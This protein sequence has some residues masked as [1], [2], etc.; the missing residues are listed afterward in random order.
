MTSTR[1]V[2]TFA[3]NLS[4]LEMST[5]SPFA[6][7]GVLQHYAWGGSRYLADFLGLPPQNQ[8]IAE[9]WM[10]MHPK[11]PATVISSGK[12]LA[13]V[14]ENNPASMLGEGISQRFDHR[15]P[16]L[17][18]ILDVQA[19][20]SI[21]VHPDKGT[22]EAGYAREEAAGIPQSAPHRNYR[23]DNHK[24]ELGVAISD[25]YLLHG[26][27]EEAAIAD[28]LRR[29]PGWAD[30]H[31]ILFEE[32][33]A[34]LYQYVME[35]SQDEVDRL[36]TPL[37]AYL[38]GNITDK[39]SPDFWAKRAIEQYSKEGHHDRGIFSI[40]W[41]NVVHL[42]PGQAIYQDAGIPHAYLEGQCFELMANSDN[43]LRGGLTPKH[44]DVA[45]LLLNT[46]TT[47]VN[48]RILRPV[49]SS[50]GWA[51]YPTPAPDFSLLFAELSATEQLL[52]KADG[53]EILLLY[54]GECSLGELSLHAEQR[55]VFIP[56]NSTL[57]LTANEDSVIY[58][59]K[60]NW[61]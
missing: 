2:F 43:V 7:N 47:A 12:S 24:P 22:A 34:G 45:E 29:I 50:E 57:T 25:F 16:F 38:S 36:L 40:Y 30:L 10:G 42:R 61:G 56:A 13:Q 26:F 44:I 21:Q 6:I 3:L 28:T 8:P 46:K 48:P 52:L 18:K 1:F 37:A 35:A 55:V 51:H 27:R 32:G 23:D 41:F 15:L 49:S 53:P 54:S 17:F 14:I 59:A 9:Y 31:P 19:M 4:V 58:R 11:G 60:V 39:T 5:N 33:V 20:L